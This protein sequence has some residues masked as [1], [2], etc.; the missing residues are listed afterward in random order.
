M[1][2][3]KK[4]FI[5]LSYSSQESRIYVASAQVEIS[6]LEMGME[7]SSDANVTFKWYNLSP[8]LQQLL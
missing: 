8:K 4:K 7:Q 3:S 6:A 1:H 2:E 5:T